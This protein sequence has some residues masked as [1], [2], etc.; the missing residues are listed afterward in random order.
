MYLT[1][2]VIY[3]GDKTVSKSVAV[4]PEDVFV[5]EN[6]NK[7][8]E[9]FRANGWDVLEVNKRTY[10]KGDYYITLISEEVNMVRSHNLETKFQ[11]KNPLSD[12]LLTFHETNNLPEIGAYLRGLEYE[13]SEEKSVV[14]LISEWVKE[15]RINSDNLQ[16]NVG[17]YAKE[18]LDELNG[19]FKAGTEEH[20]RDVLYVIWSVISC[21]LVSGYTPEQIEKGIKIMFKSNWSQASTWDEA[22][23]YLSDNKRYALHRAETSSGRSMVLLDGMICKGPNY[24]EANF[25]ELF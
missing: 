15:F 21:A 2:V 18:I 9:V 17:F 1:T 11:N 20:F 3:K 16:M 7:I 24:I 25:D 19:E 22:S 8:Q 23:E 14:D 6:I 10:T 5:G 12:L 13:N 4:F